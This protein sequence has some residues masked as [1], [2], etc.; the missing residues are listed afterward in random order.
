MKNSLHITFFVFVNVQN[1]TTHY[2]V[3]GVLNIPFI[4]LR[5]KLDYPWGN[6]SQFNFPLL[7]V[8]KCL[9]KLMRV[10]GLVVAKNGPLCIRRLAW[11]VLG[12]A[13]KCWQYARAWHR[14]PQVWGFL[15]PPVSPFLEPV[16]KKKGKCIEK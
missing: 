1:F 4:P 15:A 2:R 3:L 5:I 11:S 12:L 14:H 6:I 8:Y 9:L 16:L 13:L 7:I 10:H